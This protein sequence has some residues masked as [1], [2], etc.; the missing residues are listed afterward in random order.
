MSK[1]CEVCKWTNIGLINL[2][3]P[4]KPKMVCPGCIKRTFDTLDELER[5]FVH[6]F[7]GYQTGLVPCKRNDTFLD[8][9]LRAKKNSKDGDIWLTP[10]WF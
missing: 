6:V 9:V 2:G 7:A 3:E 4:G 8:R 5:Q 1:K 10:H